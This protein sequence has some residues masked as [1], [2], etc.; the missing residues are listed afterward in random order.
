MPRIR[1]TANPKLPRDW[2]DKPYRKDYEV[3]VSADEAERWQRRGV[4]VVVPDRPAVKAKPAAAPKEPA[5][6]VVTA[7]QAAPAPTAAP[8]AS[9]PPVA[10]SAAAKDTPA[11]SPTVFDLT[12]KP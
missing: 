1:F 10:A 12:P 3:D 9:A 8:A 6:P 7:P 11:K 4:A 2:A 5:A